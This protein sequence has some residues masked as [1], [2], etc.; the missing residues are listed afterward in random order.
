MVD[1][2][3]KPEFRNQIKELSDPKYGV[4]LS[5]KPKEDEPVATYRKL[6]ID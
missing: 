3:L 2:M 6:N 4:D 1:D 5:L